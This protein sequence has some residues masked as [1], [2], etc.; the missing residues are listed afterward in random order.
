MANQVK[1][2]ILGCASIAEK[3]CVAISEA[4][5]ATVVAV[6]SRDKAKAE[7]WAAEHCPGARAYGSYDELLNDDEI[8]VVYIPLPTGLRTEWVLKAAAKKKHVLCEKP[9]TGTIRDA[10]VVIDACKDAGVQF[11]DN[12]MFMHNERLEAMNK[13]LQDTESFGEVKHVTSS[14]TIPF[15]NDEEWAKAN[16]RTK[17]ALEPLGSLGDLGWYCVRI[18][19][20]AFGYEDPQTVSCH[21]LE[22]TPDGVPITAA[23]TMKFSGGRT[24]TFTC[25]NKQNLQQWAQVDGTKSSLRIED[26]VIPS[27]SDSCGFKVL[28]G[29]IGS[30]AL[31]FPIEVLKEESIKTTVQQHTRLVEKLSSIASSGT[32]E[33]FW[34]KV[35]LQTQLILGAMLLSARRM[36]NWVT[37]R[38]PPALEKGKGKG[39]GKG[40][41]VVPPA[42]SE[43]KK[44][45]PV[46]SNVDSV[47]PDSKNFNLQVKVVSIAEQSKGDA[48]SCLCIVGDESG[49]VKFSA[50][51]ATEVNAVKEGVSLILRNANVEMIKGHIHLQVGKWGKVEVSPEDFTF[52]PNVKNDISDVEYELVQAR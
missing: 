7:S 5:N 22:E 16:I 37:P 41:E 48:P 50:A 30:K 4:S 35:S 49:V 21:F 6:A 45:K 12:T 1:W 40:K 36:S 32:L 13:V 8:Q 34:P 11:M 38:E 9:I 26:F 28:R 27:Q 43:V 47:V 3:V 29:E 42:Q 17:R 20:A 14:F 23:A 51:G 25:C 18:T 24:A 44:K 2:G 33:D 46:F 19:L 31:N 39:K 10:R 52:S 15:G